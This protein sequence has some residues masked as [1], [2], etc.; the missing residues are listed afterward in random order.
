MTYP[1][2]PRRVLQRE[3]RTSNRTAEFTDSASG[4]TVGAQGG[5]ARRRQTWRS[6]GS[7]T[8]DPAR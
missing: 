7:Q 3:F 1:H 5:P 6:E 4:S 2:S 8:S